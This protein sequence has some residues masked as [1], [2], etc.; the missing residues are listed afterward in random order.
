MHGDIFLIMKL[1]YTLISMPWQFQTVTVLHPTADV[2]HPTLLL[3]IVIAL[4]FACG[5]IIHS[6]QWRHNGRDSISNHQPHH[7]LLNGLF[8]RR[9]KKTSK[10]RVTGLC[11][12]NSPGT[13][14]FAHKWP[15][16]RKMFP[17]DDVIMFSIDLHVITLP[18]Y[19]RASIH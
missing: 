12:V 4:V 19:L 7:C 6:L 8:R 14:E 1:A 2:E 9:S 17:F 15:V 11:A 18:I 16:T 3:L 10:L 5:Y 13:G